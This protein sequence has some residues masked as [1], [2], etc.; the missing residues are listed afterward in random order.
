MLWLK[1]ILIQTKCSACGNE[2]IISN[3]LC[4]NNLFLRAPCRCESLN[5]LIISP[6]PWTDFA[7]LIT[8]KDPKP[9]SNQIWGRWVRLDIQNR[10]TVWNHILDVWQTQGSSVCLFLLFCKT[11]I[12]IEFLLHNSYPVVRSWVL[13][14]TGTRVFF[15]LSLFYCSLAHS[16]SPFQR[17]KKKK[18]KACGCAW[19]SLKNGEKEVHLCC[20]N[21]NSSRGFVVEWLEGFTVNVLPTQRY[22]VCFF[23]TKVQ[24]DLI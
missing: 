15:F 20:E 16:K 2:E 4:Y 19:E 3:T 12:L 14:Q 1:K 6:M 8:L 23:S 11:F 7:F 18:K 9:S 13:C 17:G 24:L 21:V 22:P 5:Q 10:S